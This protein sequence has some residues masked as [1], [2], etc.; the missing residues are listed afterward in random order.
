MFVPFAMQCIMPDPQFVA[1]VVAPGAT[2]TLAQIQQFI[3]TCTVNNA[4]PRD[5]CLQMER[6][7]VCRIMSLG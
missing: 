4:S 1:G 3:Q 7:A 6:D 5:K 2:S